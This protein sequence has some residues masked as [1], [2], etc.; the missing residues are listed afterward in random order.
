VASA[1]THA[2]VG[3]S[4]GSCFYRRDISKTVWAAGALC[5]ALP[6]IDAIGFHFHV[7]YASFWGHRGFTHSL[8]FAVLL[9]V[10]VTALLFRKGASGI[11]RF[12]LFAYL[13]LA[14]ASHGLLDAMTTGGLGVAFF[15]PFNN[16]RYFLPWRPIRVSPI[17]IARFFTWR[18]IGI[19]RSEFLWV[20]IPAIVFAAAVLLLRRPAKHQAALNSKLGTRN[21]KLE[22]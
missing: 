11:G 3:L 16:R 22:A 9:A 13:F 1:F 19:L 21:S 7:P 14:T 17:S 4:I 10:L 6:D 2:V 20:W 18:G 12:P 5:A 8:F 15:S